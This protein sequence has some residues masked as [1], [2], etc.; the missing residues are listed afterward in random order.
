LF[1]FVADFR[2]V[3]TIFSA[4]QNFYRQFS[5]LSPGSGFFGASIKHPQ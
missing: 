2:L 3:L 1:N 4:R 5:Y